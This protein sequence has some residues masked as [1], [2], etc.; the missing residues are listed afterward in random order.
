MQ[1]VSCGSQCFWGFVDVDGPS[2]PTFLQYNLGGGQPVTMA[3]RAGLGRWLRLGV[4]RWH[5][6]LLQPP[7]PPPL[8]LLL[9]LLLLVC[10][11]FMVRGGAAIYLMPTHA[12]PL[13]GQEQKYV[14]VPLNI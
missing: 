3:L 7:A 14:L 6:L 2:T 11:R 12:N 4:L 9:Q 13:A 1:R 8:L 5:L 10:A